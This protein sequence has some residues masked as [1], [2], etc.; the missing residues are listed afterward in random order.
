MMEESPSVADSPEPTESV[1]S[2]RSAPEVPAVASQSAA[3]EGPPESSTRGI[4]RDAIQKVMDK[5]E[6]HER[7]AKKHLE[8]AADLRKDLRESVAFLHEQGAE[9]R[10]AKATGE[11]SAGAAAPADAKGKAKGT[12]ADTKQRGA[13]KKHGSGK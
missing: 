10:P 1:P 2:E 6:Y 5:I 8:M 11:G 3:S 7:E 13:K 4:L 12:M 9:R